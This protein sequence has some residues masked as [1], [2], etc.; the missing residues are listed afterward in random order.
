[1]TS[2]NFEKRIS[3]VVDHLPEWLRLDSASKDAANRK[4]A[5]DTLA[6]MISA[7]LKGA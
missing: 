1:M 5:E 6:A 4:R 7:A 3:H 2:E